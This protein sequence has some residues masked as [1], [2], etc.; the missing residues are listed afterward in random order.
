M[1]LRRCNKTT[2]CRILFVCL[3]KRKTYESQKLSEIKYQSLGSG[4]QQAQTFLAVYKVLALLKP[5]RVLYTATTSYSFG[6]SKTVLAKHAW[7]HQRLSSST[8]V[9][10]CQIE[11]GYARLVHWNCHACIRRISD[12]YMV[13]VPLISNLSFQL[14]RC[15]SINFILK[16]MCG[17]QSI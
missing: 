12:R 14:N 5:L 11:D 16:K 8:Y 2:A 13:S 3:L 17:S 1:F 10:T 4:C 9:R 6:C 15:S 7:Q